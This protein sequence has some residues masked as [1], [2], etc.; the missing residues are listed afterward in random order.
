[1]QGSPTLFL[2]SHCPTNK[3]RHVRVP[4]ISFNMRIFTDQ[5]NGVGTTVRFILPIYINHC[6]HLSIHTANSDCPLRSNPAV[7]HSSFY[8]CCCLYHSH[9]LCR[10]WL[11]FHP[12]PVFI[13]VHLW[14]SLITLIFLPAS[15]LHFFLCQFPPGIAVHSVCAPIILLNVFFTPLFYL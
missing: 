1:M 13:C 9:R 3:Y 7:L 14:P 6:I 11:L 5:V 15:F 10:T 2:V 4:T 8:N 12:R